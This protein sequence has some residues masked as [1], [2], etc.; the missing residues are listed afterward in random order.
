MFLEQLRLHSMLSLR[1]PA[2]NLF[3][4][5]IVK[6][7]QRYF[8]LYDIFRKKILKK[9]NK[10]THFHICLEG[11]KTEIVGLHNY[12]YEVLILKLNFRKLT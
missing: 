10:T 7:V 8:V 3:R 11:K 2:I 4:K 9:I 6:V 5:D 12:L 1:P